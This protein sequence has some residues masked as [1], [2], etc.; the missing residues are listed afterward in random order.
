MKKNLRIMMEKV[1][2]YKL[3]M[4]SQVSLVKLKILFIKMALTSKI[5]MILTAC[6][7][8]ILL[9]GILI[10]RVIHIM[11]EIQVLQVQLI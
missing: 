6:S 1:K 4:T 5:S 10:S 7:M 2:Q 3:L 8:E 9:R 11:L